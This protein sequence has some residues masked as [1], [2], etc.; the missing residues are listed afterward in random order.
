LT[1]AANSKANET[2]EETTPIRVELNTATAAELETLPGIGPSKAEAIIAQR[3]RR[4]F[5]RIE[6]IMRVKG[7]GRKTFKK[8][9]PYLTV[10]SGKKQRQSTPNSTAH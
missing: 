2:K 6:D 10:D 7:I 8:L 5:K 4:P 9:R 3:A 1:V